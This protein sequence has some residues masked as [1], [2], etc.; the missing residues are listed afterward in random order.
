MELDLFSK[1]AG[2]EKVVTHSEYDYIYISPHLDDVPLSCS[3]AIC[4]QKTQGFKILVVTVFAGD[5]QPPF[6]PFVQSFHQSW[7]ASKENPYKV[8][9]MEERKAMAALD[10]DYLW[11]DWLETLYRDPELADV[12][13]LFC[14]PS[15]RAVHPQDAPIFATLCNWL[16][17]L[18]LSYPGAQFVAP[19]SL[20]EHRDHRLVFLASLAALDRSHQLF[21]EDFPYAT[22]QAEE[23]AELVKVYQLSPIEVDISQ[24]LE[25]RMK[26]AESYQSQLP[27][28]YHSASR[29]LELIREYT[30][31]LGGHQGFVERYWK[32]AQ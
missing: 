28:L 11:F 3:G 21:F 14:E 5:P 30:S 6:S 26:A 24:C 18:R 23:L 12:I 4:Q 2:I 13:D 19:L 8:R 15:E 7:Q 9:K 31:S 32:L 27:A 20:G 17:D 25:Q 29:F 10:V 22:Y 16:A 1:Y